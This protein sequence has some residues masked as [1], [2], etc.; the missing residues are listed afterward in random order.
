[1]SKF[2]PDTEKSVR[3]VLPLSLYEKFTEKCPDR[4]DKSKVVR[5]LIRKWLMDPTII[6][7]RGEEKGTDEVKAG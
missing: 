2:N 7:Y 3:V 6:N 5:S 1:M 4:G